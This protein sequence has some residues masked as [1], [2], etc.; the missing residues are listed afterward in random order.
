MSAGSRFCAQ[1]RPRVLWSSACAREQ[2]A[3]VLACHVRSNASVGVVTTTRTTSHGHSLL[4]GRRSMTNARKTRPQS[5]RWPLHVGTYLASAICQEVL[6]GHSTYELAVWQ[7]E[8]IMRDS[9][10]KTLMGLDNEATRPLRVFFR[11]K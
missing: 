4:A 11:G 1:A 3:Q 5:N 7:A 10:K 8:V 9:T 2:R 6:D